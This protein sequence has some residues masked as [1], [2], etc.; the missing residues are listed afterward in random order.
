MRLVKLY[1]L[2]AERIDVNRIALS[3]CFTGTQLL[4][5]MWESIAPRI[6][7]VD[8]TTVADRHVT[9]MTLST[10]GLAGER[11]HI[12]TRHLSKTPL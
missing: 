9:R 12:T 11:R 5:E 2:V 1:D 7:A 10:G 3:D 4:V 8:L 6:R